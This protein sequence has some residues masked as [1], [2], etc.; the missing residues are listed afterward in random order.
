MFFL[1]LIFLNPTE[2]VRHSGSIQVSCLLLYFILKEP[3]PN[4]ESI[5][6][7][8]RNIFD[9]N[10]EN[11]VIVFHDLEEIINNDCF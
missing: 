3:Q 2:S 11:L 5:N 8:S 1:C 7:L 4:S 9:P 10:E 6:E